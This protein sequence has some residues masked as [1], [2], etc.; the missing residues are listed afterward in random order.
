ML[1]ACNRPVCCASNKSRTT[2]RGCM[3][4]GWAQAMV[5]R[6]AAWVVGAG[7]PPRHPPGQR[8]RR[9]LSGG[10]LVQRGGSKLGHPLRGS[11]DAR[12]GLAN[13]LLP[14][15]T[16]QASC[17]SPPPPP[18]GLLYADSS[19]ECVLRRAGLDGVVESGSEQPTHGRRASPVATPAGTL[20]S[21]WTPL[22]QSAGGPTAEKAGRAAQVHG[23]SS[24]CLDWQG[25]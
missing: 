15:A 8:P 17:S 16:F 20:A 19:A 11:I 2:A 24:I 9:C 13:P 12:T 23:A 21:T 1:I 18:A 7:S 22:W 5:D 25:D 14:P 10:W 4:D 3:Q 6:P